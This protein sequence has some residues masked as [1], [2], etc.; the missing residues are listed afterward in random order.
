MKEGIQARKDRREH[1]EKKAPQALPDRKA[2][3]V[4]LALKGCRE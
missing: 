2:Q 1:K 3:Q 4:S